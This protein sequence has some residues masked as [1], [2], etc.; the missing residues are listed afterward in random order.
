MEK[1][2]LIIGWNRAGRQEVE[3][4]IGTRLKDIEVIV[5]SDASERLMMFS[6]TSSSTSPDGPLL[7]MKMSC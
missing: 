2:W 7:V 5:T 6:T 3:R 4:E 1:N